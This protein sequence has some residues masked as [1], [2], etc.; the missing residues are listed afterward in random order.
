MS[1][2]LKQQVEKLLYDL[3]L[4]LETMKY[5]LSDRAIKATYGSITLEAR[6][7]DISK[8]IDRLRKILGGTQCQ[9]HIPD[10]A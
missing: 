1:D 6:I 7:S 8:T 9:D 5:T 3:E 2:E 10:P 4:S